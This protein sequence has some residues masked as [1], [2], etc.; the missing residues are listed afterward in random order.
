MEAPTFLSIFPTIET[1]NH[2]VQQLLFAVAGNSLLQRHVG[3]SSLVPKV[4]SDLQPQALASEKIKQ[5]SGAAW[6]S[7]TVLS[8]VL[9]RAQK[10]RKAGRNLTDSGC[11]LSTQIPCPLES[12]EPMVTISRLQWAPSG[13]SRLSKNTNFPLISR[14]NS[15]SLLAWSVARG[16]WT[17][18]VCYLNLDT[19]DLCA[20]GT[21]CH[22]GKAWISKM[23]GV[24]G[25][26]IAG[27]HK[28]CGWLL[29]SSP[30]SWKGRTTPV[31]P[32]WQVNVQVGVQL[33][34]ALFGDLSS[35]GW[36]HCWEGWSCGPSDPL[37][38]SPAE[39]QSAPAGKGRT[40]S[41]G[42]LAQS[43]FNVSCFSL[44]PKPRN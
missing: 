26:V 39:G 28:V 24:A 5:R 2:F 15:A 23:N 13:A 8:G 27:V 40:H 33:I 22:W 9:Y 17:C 7:W 14:G 18:A 29:R 3:S 41:W 44:I 34:Q 37:T 10:T 11:H 16:C 4:C 32:V 21:T 19:W 12:L 36:G 42:S 20:N 25:P 30:A 6:I 31:V 38:S 1:L 43:F 35:C